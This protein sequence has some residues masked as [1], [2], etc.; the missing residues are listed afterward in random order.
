[1]SAEPVDQLDRLGGLQVALEDLPPGLFELV[2]APHSA[3]VAPDGAQ[4]LGLGTGE[5]G[6]VLEQRPASALE[7]LGDGR[8]G[9]QAHLLPQV[10]AQLLE[11]ISHGLHDMERSK[12]IT[13][14]GAW[15]SARHAAGERRAHVHRHGRDLGRS[16]RA[17]L[18]EEAVER[19]GVLALGPPHH[20]ASCGGW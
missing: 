10:A 7:P 12:Q 17:E 16:L 1:M 6:R 5:V 15:P 13:A 19:L 18:V 3:A 8:I 9:E 14:W 11:G 4:D 2:A 20:L